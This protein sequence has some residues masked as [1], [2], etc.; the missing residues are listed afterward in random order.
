MALSTL[1]A[2]LGSGKW[3]ANVSHC[4]QGAKTRD[5]VV[6]GTPPVHSG[7]KGRKCASY[8]AS[9]EWWSWS[10]GELEVVCD[11]IYLQSFCLL[12]W[13]EHELSLVAYVGLLG[14]CRGNRQF[15]RG[16]CLLGSPAEAEI[17]HRT[18]KSAGTMSADQSRFRCSPAQL[19]LSLHYCKP[20]AFLTLGNAGS[21]GPIPMGF[22]CKCPGASCA[23]EGFYRGA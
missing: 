12:V 7:A 19:I 3:A 6:Q 22:P 18:Q 8:K 21:P 9:L 23:A 4:K 5:A 2:R 15:R 14:F 20:L 13:L 16:L 11:C 10:S 1:A 17:R